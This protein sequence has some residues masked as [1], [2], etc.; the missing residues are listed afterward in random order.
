MTRKQDVGKT[1]EDEAVKY[2]EGR[3]YRIIERNHRQKWGELD[4]VA[5]APDKTLVF[6]EVKAISQP[7][8]ISPEENLKYD[9]LRKLR[10][11]AALYANGHPQLAND[12]Q[13]WRIDLLAINLTYMSSSD[14]IRHYENI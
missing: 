13:S 2:L 6:V 10:R 9:K 3:G 14:N 11:T 7:G 4:I 12:K 5:K 8:D 1:G